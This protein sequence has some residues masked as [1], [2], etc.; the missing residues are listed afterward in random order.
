MSR[1]ESF[2]RQFPASDYPD[3]AAVTAFWSTVDDETTAFVQS[4]PD[5]ASLVRTYQRSLDDGSVIERPLWG[6]MLHIVN[7]GTQ[8]RSEVAAM[9]TALG[10]SPGNLDLL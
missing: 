5:D 6:M 4:L 7:H 3:L 1:D 8:H 2:A 9:L 10:H